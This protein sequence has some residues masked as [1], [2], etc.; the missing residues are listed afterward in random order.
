MERQCLESDRQAQYWKSKYES[1]HMPLEAAL[2]KTYRGKNSI[3]Y[4]KTYF[5][6]FT[7]LN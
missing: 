6:L 4:T 7:I 2:S 1:E 3:T 5:P